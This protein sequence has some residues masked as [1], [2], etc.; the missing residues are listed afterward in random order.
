MMPPE[1]RTV[2]CVRCAA[3][4]QCE[5]WGEIGMLPYGWHFELDSTEVRCP[6]CWMAGITG[7]IE[8][9]KRS[10]GDPSQS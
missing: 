10:M 8:T 5:P 2:V 1:T 3:R 7:M 6:D 4:G 9:A